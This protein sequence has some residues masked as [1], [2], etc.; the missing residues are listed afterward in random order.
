MCFIWNIIMCKN[1]VWEKH[2]LNHFYTV[3]K[4][5]VQ[6]SWST[7]ILNFIFLTYQLWKW[8]LYVW[9]NLLSDYQVESPGIRIPTDDGT[10][11]FYHLHGRNVKISNNGVRALRPSATGE[12]NDA[13]IMSNRALRDGERFEIVIEKMVDRWSGSIEA[14]QC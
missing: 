6:L 12:F 14:G 3:K 2:S 13:I 7:W 5:A 10:L 11:R 8:N 4:H 1:L 9:M